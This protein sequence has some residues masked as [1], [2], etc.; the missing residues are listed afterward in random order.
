MDFDPRDYDDARDRDD[1][2]YDSRWGDNPRDADARDLTADP[3]HHDPRDTFVRDLD[4]PRG[5]ERELVEDDRGHLY[6]L[7]GDDSREC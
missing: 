4:L 6:E 7:N 2:M 3:R 1:G 5:L